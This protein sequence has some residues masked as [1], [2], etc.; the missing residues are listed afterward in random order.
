M[1]SQFFLANNDAACSR[2][3]TSLKR[4]C[5]VPSKEEK[6]NVSFHSNPFERLGF[7]SYISNSQVGKHK[8][9][10]KKEEKLF[11]RPSNLSPKIIPNRTYFFSP[12]NLWSLHAKE[13]LS[14][15][16]L[17]GEE[18][19]GVGS[20][21]LSKHHLGTSR[22]KIHFSELCNAVCSFIFFLILKKDTN[23]DF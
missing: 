3:C 8:F 5:F 4:C 2:F 6:M 16:R 14:F 10:I 9:Q 11:Q 12:W 19:N 17:E 18:K 22:G 23:A 1:L 13:S 21:F 15:Q 20:K 7:I